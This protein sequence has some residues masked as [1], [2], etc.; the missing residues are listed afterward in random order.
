MSVNVCPDNIFSVCQIVSVQY[1]LNCSII[2]FI[3]IFFL[4]RTWYGGVLSRDDVYAQKLV[5]YLQCQ[6]HSEGI[7]NQNMTIFTISFKLLVRVQ[8]TW[9]DS[10]A[11]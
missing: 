2:F 8:Q 4:N 10:T 11:S 1:L 6:G 3:F 5:H 7:Y 9:F